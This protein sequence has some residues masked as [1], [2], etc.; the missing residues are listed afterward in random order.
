LAIIL[1]GSAYGAKAEESPV[2]PRASF[3]VIGGPTSVPYGWA[4]FCQRYAGECVEGPSVPQ[5]I[6]LTHK[7]WAKIKSVNAFVNRAVVPVTDMEH[8]QVLDRW[9]Y[10]Y[11]GKGDCED[12]AL[13]KRRLL[14]EAGFPRQALLMSVVKDEQNEGHAVLT[15]KTDRGEFV[16][17]NLGD[18]AKPWDQTSYRFVKRQSQT[19]ENIWVQ[20]G[21]PTPPPPYVSR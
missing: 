17:D 20:V 21:E 10:P 11:D 13:Y 5:D 12:F 3:A 19:D 4:D 6:H 9:D 14:I 18:A 7:A 2:L 1:I 15:L 16:L 8:W